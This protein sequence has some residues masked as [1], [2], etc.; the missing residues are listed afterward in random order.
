M[1]L[2]TI[3]METFYAQDY[4]LSKITTEDYVRSDKFEV[5][6]LAV[7]VNN[8]ATE[9]ASG[10]HEQINEW[11][12][13]FNWADAMVVCHNTMFDGAI[14][15]WRFGINPRVWADT[16][17]MGRALHGIEVGG[18]LKAMAERYKV[19]V[20]GEEVIAAKGKRR[21]DF[22]D[23]ELD[24]YGDYCINDVEITHKL[25]HLMAK[26]FPKKEFKLIDVTL[27]MFIEPVLELDLNLL[28]QHLTDI[29]D[30]KEKLLES[31]NVDISELMSNQK[32]AELLRGFGVEP[33]MKVSLTTG[34]QT[35]AFAKSDEGF[36]A[37][38]DHHD[39][40]VQALVAA[41]LGTKSTLEETRTQRFIDIAN[42]G[43]LPVPL[44]YYG[45]KTGRWAAEGSINMQN[46]PRKSALKKAITAPEGHVIVGA[47]LS[48]I[49]LR[50]GLWLAGQM[51]KLKLLGDGCDLYKDFA[52]SVFNIGYDDVTP[53]QRF[54]GKTSQLSLIYGV[55]AIKLRAA[56]KQGSGVDIGEAESQR[57]V[58][59]YR[60]EYD[61][62]RS[63]W[64]DGMGVIESIAAGA[65][66]WF[67][68]NEFIKVHGS[69]GMLLPS[70]IYMRFDDLKYDLVD[71]RKQWHYY[72]RRGRD[73]I[74][75]SKVFQGL[76]QAI[77]RCIMA[78][79]ML[80]IQK[81][82]PIAL[83]IH[84]A[85]YSVVPEHEASNAVNLIL[86]VMRTTPA[87][88][89]GLPLDAE[90]GYGQTLADC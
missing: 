23:A 84:D 5:I 9:W 37:L 83:T 65:T 7:K 31:V 20:K 64:Q 61:R 28:E 86:S 62:V 81:H 15:A 25:F 78:E 45:A 35:L 54:I 22:T 48:N 1:D 42:R 30:T 19:G 18:S 82:Y 50:V 90:A 34:K 26:G 51:D 71:G 80:E 63:I 2:I 6:G 47:D 36:K 11:L 17:C 68:N 41:R 57:I 55:G 67:G 77:A 38:A 16:L 70:G 60:T 14:L 76:T 43:L 24:R 73:R 21:L 53:E 8:N 4:S 10:T 29:K 12:Q 85:V 13:T 44:R 69:Q 40:R 72:V 88:I 58:M 49:E 3:D 32:F 52:S 79:Q 56:L 66:T 59:L 87:W 33:P 75:G 46:I 27:R 74:Y 89:P 39:V